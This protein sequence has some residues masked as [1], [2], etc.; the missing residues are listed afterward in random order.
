MAGGVDKALSVELLVKPVDG[1]S[2]AGSGLLL[3]NPPFGLEDWLAD[4]LPQ[5]KAA[6]APQHGS[7]AVRWLGTS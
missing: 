4:A 6:L 3:I 5:L 2:L 1:V 7:H